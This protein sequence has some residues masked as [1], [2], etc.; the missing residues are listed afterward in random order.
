MKHLL[1]AFISLI[2]FRS[3]VN[4]QVSSGELI[5]IMDSSLK[6]LV[7]LQTK[8]KDIHPCLNEFHPVAIPY[9][10]SLLIFDYNR[11][12]KS[13]QFIKETG[14]PFPLPE[15]IQASFPL[16]VYDNKPTCIVNTKTFSA[17]AGYATVM[18]EFI[19]C[20]QFN[21]VEPEIKEELE[22]YKSAM[23]NRDY[24]WEIVHPFPYDDSIIHQ[25]DY[26]SYKE[27][28]QENNIEKAREI[29]NII[30][31][32][33][34]KTDFEYMVWEEWKEG[35]A[36]YVENKILDKLNI[37]RNNYGKDEPY[38]RVS[39]YYSGELLISRLAEKDP[40]L[41]SEMKKLFEEMRDF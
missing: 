27:A 17:T 23:Q 4:A 15:G 9:K 6:V 1:I 40:Q 30:K 33:L 19:H 14:Q 8:V 3:S 24:S 20:C 29:R 35:L 39:F 37:S 38:N 10:D 21:S 18:H 11:A 5:S 26:D 25:S 41:P 31:G 28:L 34:N 2:A 36:R 32:H 12:E 7:E 22:I 13:Y 16:P